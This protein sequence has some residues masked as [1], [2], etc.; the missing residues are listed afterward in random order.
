MVDVD[1]DYPVHSFFWY[2]K[3]RKNADTAPL[4]I[5][6]S[7]GPGASSMF[8]IFTENGPCSVTEHLTAQD[9][10]WSWNNEYNI[11]YLDQPVQTGFSYDTLTH[12]F[13]N[14]TTGAIT[15]SDSAEPPPH[16][17]TT[18]PGL[19]GSQ[20]ATLTANTTA[21]AAR[22]FWNFLQV[23]ERDFK[24]HTTTD[25]SVAIWTESYGGRYGPGFSTYIQQ[26]NMRISEGELNGAIP[27]NLTTL[28][29]INGC[30]DLETQITSRPEFAYDRNPYNIL[31][32]TRHN[33]SDA[34]I[35]YS[36][37]GGCHDQILECLHWAETNDPH[38]LGNH[39]ETNRICER[40]SDF[41][42]NEVEGPY[43]FRK[44]W[45]F[46][47]ITHCYLDPTPPNFFVD[48]LAMKEVRDALK[49][50]V[51]YTDIS[52]AVGT[53]FN[54]T[55]DFVRRD[56]QGYLQDIGGLLNDGIQVAM[57]YG[58]RDFACNW[59]GGERA[60]LAVEYQNSTGFHKAGYTDVTLHEKAEGQV[61]QHGLFS[62]TRVYQ[63]GHMVPASQPEVAYHIFSRVM[64]RNDVATG[65]VPLDTTYSS[66]GTFVSNTT[67]PVLDSPQPTCWLRAMPATC[68]QNQIDAVVDG[69]AVFAK[70]GV[71]ISP[72][73]PDGICPTPI[74][75]F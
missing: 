55:G 8:A 43:S 36:E 38:M 50:P 32:I 63:S 31:G 52:G 56:P 1:H 66:N 48:Y 42:Q 2:F 25:R 6:V 47:D 19:F 51:N 40:A 67:L 68:A 22:Q 23:F 14:V 45:A 7:G 20:N 16:D 30:V 13:L 65:Q 12:G 61:R 15:P 4:V 58:D 33:Y 57:V 9:N 24:I 10:P 46:Y 69:S 54:R 75:Y 44:K 72:K 71:I 41:C 37:K 49:V 27:I 35:A 3:A 60:S 26:Q 39:R 29:I 28:G 34:L 64:N 21:N 74:N 5:W 18:I 53:A 62:F 59:I 73:F 70:N 11:L 17:N